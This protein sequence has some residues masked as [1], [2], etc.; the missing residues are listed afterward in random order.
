MKT[1]Y[2][3][4]LIEEGSAFIMEWEGRNFNAKKEGK[5]VKQNSTLLP[6]Y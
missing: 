3:R 5:W 1:N 6:T 2:G 4:Y